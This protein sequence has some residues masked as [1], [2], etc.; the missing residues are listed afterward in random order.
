MIT[1][2]GLGN[3]RRNEMRRDEIDPFEIADFRRKQRLEDCDDQDTD[4]MICEINTEE[5]EDYESIKDKL[6]VAV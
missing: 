5:E 6:G 3:E 4:L 2:F 1:E